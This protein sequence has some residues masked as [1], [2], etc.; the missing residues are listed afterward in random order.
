MTNFDTSGIYALIYPL[1]LI[2]G[3]YLGRYVVLK[4]LLESFRICVDSV[5]DALKDDSLSI[6]EIKKIWESCYNNFKKFLPKK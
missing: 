4:N 6:E 2:I 3:Y 5:D 1:L